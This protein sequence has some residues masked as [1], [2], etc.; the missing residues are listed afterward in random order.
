MTNMQNGQRVK[1]GSTVAIC[2]GDRP[3]LGE[4]REGVLVAPRRHPPVGHRVVRYDDGSQYAVP[5]THI[6][7]V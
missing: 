3:V 4:W 6:V 7:V 2:N 1:V 5:I